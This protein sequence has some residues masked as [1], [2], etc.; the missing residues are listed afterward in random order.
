MYSIFYSLY[1]FT[2]IST[3][4]DT[5]TNLF[6]SGVSKTRMAA[7]SGVFNLSD[8]RQDRTGVY[9]DIGGGGMYVLKFHGGTARFSEVGSRKGRTNLPQFCLRLAQTAKR[10]RSATI[11]F[12]SSAARGRS[13]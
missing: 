9:H 8:A 3:T 2:F 7:S 11:A 12:C 5:H 4:C 1:Q 13:K 6:Y 10:H